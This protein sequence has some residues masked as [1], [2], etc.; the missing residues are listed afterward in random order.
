VL[1]QEASD[2]ADYRISAI[3]D[4][5]DTPRFVYTGGTFRPPQGY[6]ENR[7]NT[8]HVKVACLKTPAPARAW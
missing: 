5:R 2:A 8:F 6:I 7:S 4:K 3:S 1:A